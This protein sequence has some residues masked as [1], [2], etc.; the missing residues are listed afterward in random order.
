LKNSSALSCPKAV[1]ADPR[2]NAS[3]TARKNGLD[4]KRPWGTVENTS[5]HSPSRADSDDDDDDEDDD[6]DEDDED[7]DDDDDD[8]CREQRDSMYSRVKSMFSE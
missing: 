2:R 3:W 8:D 6:E 5:S 1:V 4:R 7:D